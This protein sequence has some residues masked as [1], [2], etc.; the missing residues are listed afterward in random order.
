[1]AD[2]AD[3]SATNGS[4]V[5]SFKNSEGKFVS[6]RLCVWAGWG[7]MWAISLAAILVASF[8]ASPLLFLLVLVGI[9]G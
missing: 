6:V 2:T 9:I 7:A 3:F 4:N 8:R 5:D 1:M